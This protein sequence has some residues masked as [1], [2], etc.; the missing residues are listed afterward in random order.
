MVRNNT[1]ERPSRG[2]R[3]SPVG[4]SASLGRRR[5]VFN[6]AGRECPANGEV[7]PASGR[8]FRLRYLKMAT[9][10]YV[11]V[12]EDVTSLIEKMHELGLPTTYRLS[13]ECLV[14]LLLGPQPP[15]SALTL[16]STRLARMADAAGLDPARLVAAHIATATDDTHP[17]ES[18]E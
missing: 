5:P 12:P 18:E 11:V 17:T 6:T 3:D 7:A 4:E 14:D 9:P 13:A 10:G 8:V 16:I 1:T 15:S 2:G